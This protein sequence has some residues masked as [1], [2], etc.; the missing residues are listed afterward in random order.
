MIAAAK[1]AAAVENIGNLEFIQG[2]WEDFDLSLL[3]KK[4]ISTVLCASA[5]HNFINP[6]VAAKRMYESLNNDGHFF[7]WKEI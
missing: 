6:A 5:F 3:W 2:N 7:F 4:N 1:R